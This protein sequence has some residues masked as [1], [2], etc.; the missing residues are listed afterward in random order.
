M[1]PRHLQHLIRSQGAAVAPTVALSLFGLI[2]V[3]G[4]AFDYARMA[5]L[6]T[7]L[8][9]AADQA[10]L[11]AATQL[12][13][14]SDAISRATDAAQKLIKNN[15][16]FANDQSSDGSNVTI[17][18]IKFYSAFTDDGDDTNDTETSKGEDAQFVKVTTNPRTARYALTPIVG[19]LYTNNLKGTAVA[20]MESAICNVPP[21]MMCNPAETAGN[22]DAYANTSWT[23]STGIGIRLSADATAG[24][25]P[26]N[27]GFLD[28]DLTNGA[29]AGADELKVALSWDKFPVDCIPA[30]KVITKPGMMGNA[31]LPYINE[32]FDIPQ[33][34]QECPKL[35]GNSGTCSSGTNVRKDV[36][37]TKTGKNLCTDWQENPYPATTSEYNATTYPNNPA[38]YE[39]PSSGSNLASTVTPKIMGL[40][41]DRCHAI[42]GLN[43][44]G[45][46]VNPNTKTS[47][48]RLGD[49]NWDIN[50][51]W[52]ANYGKA[53][54][55][56][57]GTS[58]TRY[59][60]Y[61][62]ETSIPLTKLGYGGSTAYSTRQCMA[63]SASNP[64]KRRLSIAIV[65]CNAQNSKIQGKSSVIVAKWID[66]F[67]VEPVLHR[68]RCN[69]PTIKG[70]N[71]NWTCADYT[72]DTD[73]YLELIG[74]TPASTGAAGAPV[75]RSI[76]YLVQ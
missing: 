74:E 20:G 70:S 65:N 7:E 55:N 57:L 49:G 26:G 50:A 15:A 53:Y 32:R 75:R 18:T 61:K 44:V 42:A 60:V 62:S 34:G 23:A 51:Y 40:P 4:I 11:A 35:K 54:D 63:Q 39:A 22:T 19:V 68:T 21:L 17:P 12:D 45:N 48:Y 27:F 5:T 33:N 37:S 31:V 36:V 46:C 73:V 52:R 43:G 41:R 10:A 3:G 58:P 76:P 59:D 13:G 64:D 38:R 14:K 47:P 56:S 71:V 30:A 2:A 8:Q 9:Q 25:G 1:R 66:V 28:T 72:P 29:G 6:D 24:I 69:T 67:L 16:L